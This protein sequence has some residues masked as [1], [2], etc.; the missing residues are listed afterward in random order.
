MYKFS[1]VSLNEKTYVYKSKEL[2]QKNGLKKIKV[3]S[4]MSTIVL[5]LVDTMTCGTL[6]SGS[7][8]AYNLWGWDGGSVL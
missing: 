8:I 3:C 2:S 6:S 4:N 1:L 7:R 5:S